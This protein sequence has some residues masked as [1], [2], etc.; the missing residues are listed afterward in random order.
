MRWHLFRYRICVNYYRLKWLKQY[1]HFRYAILLRNTDDIPWTGIVVRLDWSGTNFHYFFIFDGIS[2]DYVDF[3]SRRALNSKEE[4]IPGRSPRQG[5][6]I[7]NK[8]VLKLKNSWQYSKWFEILFWRKFAEKM[9]FYEKLRPLEL[10]QLFNALTYTF[11]FT[12]FYVY[13]YFNGQ[14]RLC[15]KVNLFF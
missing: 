13:V 11:T 9:H 12:F 2:I 3:I 1:E 4:S 8:N 10:I 15:Q 7:R 14:I 6:F 5:L